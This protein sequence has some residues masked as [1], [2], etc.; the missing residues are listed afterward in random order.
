MNIWSMKSVLFLFIY[1]HFPHSFFMSEITTFFIIPNNYTVL[2][3]NS[4]CDSVRRQ[5]KIMVYLEEP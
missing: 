2:S 3:R 4:I 5:E 1:V